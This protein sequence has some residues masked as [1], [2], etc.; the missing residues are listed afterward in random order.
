MRSGES[1]CAKENLG[2]VR[3]QDEQRCTTLHAQELVDLVVLLI[4]L[5]HHRLH[6]LGH[7]RVLKVLLRCMRRRG[8]TRHSNIV[9][10]PKNLLAPPP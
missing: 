6:H 7:S 9:S 5:F 10:M 2:K 3:E 8:R 4:N 1:L